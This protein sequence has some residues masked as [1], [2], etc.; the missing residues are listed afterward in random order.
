MKIS[1]VVTIFGFCKGLFLKD[2][3]VGGE[4]NT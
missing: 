3:D 1:A 4:E 2:L